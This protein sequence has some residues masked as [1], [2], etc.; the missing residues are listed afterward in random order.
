MHL[1][2]IAAFAA[3]AVSASVLADGACCQDDGACVDLPDAQLCELIFSGTWQGDETSCATVDCTTGA[4]CIEDF[5]YFC[6]ESQTEGDVNRLG[7]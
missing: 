1:K 5:K 7:E 4:C 3:F 2:I 6:Y